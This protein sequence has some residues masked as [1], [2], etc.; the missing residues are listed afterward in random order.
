MTTG[1]VY[2]IEAP[3]D[4]DLIDGRTEGRALCE[5][6]RLAEIPHWYSLTTTM[7]AFDESL[8]ARLAEAYTKFQLPP[9]LHLSMHGNDQGVRITDGTFLSWYDLQKALVPLTNAMNGGLLICMS[10]C[11][12]SAGC[13]MAMHE[14]KDQPFWALVG[15]NTSAL[16]A[17]AAVA[18]ITFYHLFFKGQSAEQCV[19]AMKHAS[20]DHNFML[21]SGHKVKADWGALMSQSRRNQLAEALRAGGHGLFSSGTGTGLLTDA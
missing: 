2:V 5:A 18:Y 14:E 21:W 15:N 3:S 4:I 8:G 9:I 7:R 20:G 11:F 12:G 16:W 10:S 19:E 1:F 6:L 17:D 13:R